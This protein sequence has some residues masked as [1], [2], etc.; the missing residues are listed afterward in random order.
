[1]QAGAATPKPDTAPPEKTVDPAPATSTGE[2][3]IL[4]N[5]SAL[6][7]QLGEQIDAREQQLVQKTEHQYRR[8][9]QMVNNTIMNLFTSVILLM[10]EVVKRSLYH[11]LRHTSKELQAH[12][13]MDLGRSS[14]QVAFV[15]QGTQEQED[16]QNQVTVTTLKH[17]QQ[18]WRD[19]LKATQPPEAS[20]ENILVKQ[21]QAAFK[22]LDC[23]RRVLVVAL[24]TFQTNQLQAEIRFME[25]IYALK[26]SNVKALW[27]RLQ[28]VVQEYKQQQQHLVT[29]TVAAIQ[30]LTQKINLAQKKLDTDRARFQDRLTKLWAAYKANTQLADDTSSE[31]NN[32]RVALDVLL[33][34][35]IFNDYMHATELLQQHWKTVAD[36][37]EGL[38]SKSPSQKTTTFS[39]TKL[40]IQKNADKMLFCAR[41]RAK[42]L[43]NKKAYRS[44]EEWVQALKKWDN[45]MR[46]L[47]VEARALRTKQVLPE[48][49]TAPI[50]CDNQSMI[51]AHRQWKRL[52]FALTPL[53]AKL[54]QQEVALEQQKS[55]MYSVLLNK[56]GY[57]LKT[58]LDNALKK[59]TQM[60][61]NHL[62]SEKARVELE[63]SNFKALSEKYVLDSRYMDAELHGYGSNANQC[64]ELVTKLFKLKT[65]EEH[66]RHLKTELQQLQPLVVA[67]SKTVET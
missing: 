22:Q 11:I 20:V 8:N 36:H 33:Q 67:V 63:E 60:E 43:Q 25:T 29:A 61:E 24:Q 3:V 10:R 66:A 47:E 14:T 56:V 6:L 30:A 21:A 46:Q 34:E 37:V 17:T 65:W 32:I 12:F 62:D 39:P 44:T 31:A 4:T 52:V 51:V 1:M 35:S 45:D 49:V 50:L 48:Q 13:D 40:A 5:V 57:Q 38:G 7:Q 9:E 64:R 41:S 16:K 42:V 54:K 15:S 27:H 55:T 18:A 2:D 23:H 58:G 19:A 28:L 26:T 59:A 53:A